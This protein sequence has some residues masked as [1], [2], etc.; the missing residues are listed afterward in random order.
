MKMRPSSDT[1]RLRKKSESRWFEESGILREFD[2]TARSP[3]AGTT[4]SGLAE[5]KP[6]VRDQRQRKTPVPRSGTGALA[7]I[8]LRLRRANCR[9]DSLLGFLSFGLLH[10]SGLHRL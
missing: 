10:G 6:A 9:V 5:G 3:D 8:I 2:F 4:P 1:A 7:S